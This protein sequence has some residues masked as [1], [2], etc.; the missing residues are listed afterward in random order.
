[1]DRLGHPDEAFKGPDAG[2]LLRAFV[3]H[4][5]C[6]LGSYLQYPGPGHSPVCVLFFERV[7]VLSQIQGC[8]AEAMVSLVTGLLHFVAL[9]QR[10]G[11]HVCCCSSFL[12]VAV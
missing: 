6:P 10:V 8:R 7:F 2:V 4:S 1:M 11:G 3:R 5:P 9:L 12:F